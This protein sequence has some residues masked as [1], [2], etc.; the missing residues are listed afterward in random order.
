MAKMDLYRETLEKY[1]KALGPAEDAEISWEYFRA[2]Y[3]GLADLGFTELLTMEETDQAQVWQ[4]VARALMGTGHIALALGF[5]WQAGVNRSVLENLVE[6]SPEAKNLS[7]RLVQGDIYLNCPW[8]TENNEEELYPLTFGKP[9]EKFLVFEQEGDGQRVF[10]ASL[11]EG[12]S[13]Y[14]ERFG[15]AGVR[16][17]RLNKG[18]KVL[19]DREYLGRISTE[20]LKSIRNLENFFLLACSV[21]LAYQAWKAGFRYSQERRQFGRKLWEFQVLQHSLAEAYSKYQVVNVAF[22]ELTEHFSR[23]QRISEGSEVIKGVA[24]A[25]LREITDRALQVHGGSGYMREYPVQ[26]FWRDGMLLSL[27]SF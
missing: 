26:R 18:E 20:S 3:K 23:T 25:F 16:E 14:T 24:L 27:Y 19:T 7:E 15:W 12:F 17:V 21:E 9:E 5:L 4:T 10:L 1:L 8:L 6:A 13:A 22:Q 2:F 11:Q